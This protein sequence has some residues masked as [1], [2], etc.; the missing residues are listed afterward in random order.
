MSVQLD[1]EIIRFLEDEQT[2][3]VV[4]T[5]GRS[6][7]VNASVKDTLHL[8]EDGQIEFL[9][10]LESSQTSQNL[11]YC[12]WFA[13]KISI[14]LFNKNKS[15]ELK[16]IPVTSIIEGTRFQDAYKRVKDKYH[17]EYDLS[18]IW[19]VDI[20]EVKDKNLNERFLQERDTYPIITHLDRLRKEQL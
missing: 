9:E 2:V 15:Y 8:N 11:I 18:A 13:K 17:G 4:S 20:T 19:V 12:L 14:L 7:E 1:E 6:G 10:Y 16:G 5:V 3:T